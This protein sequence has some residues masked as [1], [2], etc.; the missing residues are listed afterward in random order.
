MDKQIIVD[1]R[2]QNEKVEKIKNKGNIGIILDKK[3]NN[4]NYFTEEEFTFIDLAKGNNL[5]TLL[6]TSKDRIVLISDDW[7]I[8]PLENIIAYAS[9]FNK[10]VY[11]YVKDKS[12]LEFIFNVLEKGVD[13]VLVNPDI[14]DDALRVMERFNEI[15]IELVEAEVTGVYDSGAGERACV[16]TTSILEKEEGLLVGNFANFLFLVDSENY[17]NKFVD[18]RPFRVNAGAIHSYTLCSTDKTS[19]LSELKANKRILAVRKDGKAREVTVGRVKIER[20]PLIMVEAT[21]N[22][23]SGS[24]IVQRAETVNLVS[25]SGPIQVTKIKEGNKVLVF[26]PKV[27]ARHTGKEFDEFIV[28]K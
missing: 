10:N 23:T 17:E 13:G 24:I 1:L 22:D 26:M 11:Y 19:Y 3:E 6:R 25:S 4:G 7:K 8:I 27:R 5:D 15:N 21:A 28:E 14:F 9:K 20:R 12:D 16:D 18:V 2:G